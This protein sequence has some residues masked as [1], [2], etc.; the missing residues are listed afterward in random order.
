MNNLFWV[1][2]LISVLLFA[3]CNKNEELNNDI[4]NVPE[5]TDSTQ[6]QEAITTLEDNEDYSQ[7]KLADGYVIG[8]IDDK[9]IYNILM[10][11]EY[12]S[13]YEFKSDDTNFKLKLEKVTGTNEETYNFTINGEKLK[14]NYIDENG[15]Q[16][17]IIVGENLDERIGVI[18]LNEIDNYKELVIDERHG[19]DGR[20]YIY[21]VQ[22]DEFVLLNDFELAWNDFCNLNGRWIFTYY[23]TPVSDVSEGYWVY[24]NDKFEFIDRFING[25][26]VT[27]ENG[28][29]SRNYQSMIWKVPEEN[30]GISKS[31]D[32]LYPQ[33][34]AG[35]E[36][37]FVAKRK[38]ISQKFG[39]TIVHD[40]KI[41]NDSK[42]SNGEKISA[43]TIL[44][45][46]NI[47]GK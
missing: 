1:V 36:Y 16:K 47:W 5:V 41:I 15:E 33:L 29:Y 13:S 3:G 28:E 38:I 37:S 30:G 6:Q 8:P 22:K 20:I 32:D 19:T 14:I 24:Q 27:N 4:N 45:N 9:S 34:L 40:I 35:T 44:E 11:G 21:R 10:N 23:F 2:S 17:Q 18:D 46:V 31:I 12:E 26:P 25:E 43:G 39:E 42:W 7:Y